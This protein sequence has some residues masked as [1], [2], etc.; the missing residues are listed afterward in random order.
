MAQSMTDGCKIIK[1]DKRHGFS[2][3]T[4]QT[5]EYNVAVY[6]AGLVPFGTRHRW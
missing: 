6:G 1:K 2:G 4:G 3:R 5:K